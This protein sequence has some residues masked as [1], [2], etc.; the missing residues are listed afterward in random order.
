MPEPKNGLGE[1][2]DYS[3]LT[4]S[5]KAV[6]DYHVE[7]PSWSRERVADEA[8]CTPGYVN[9]VLASYPHIV[10]EREAQVNNNHE[11]KTH[12]GN[13]SVEGEID[14]TDLPGEQTIQ[15]RPVK[16]TTAD[17]EGQSDEL[18]DVSLH[19]DQLWVLINESSLDEQLRYML[20][21]QSVSSS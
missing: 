8:G 19:P 21:D 17:I 15:D 13:V 18:V 16:R 11:R 9:D 7:N 3:E 4:D 5:Q 14:L 1:K 10:E 2:Y 12:R 6:V 20:F